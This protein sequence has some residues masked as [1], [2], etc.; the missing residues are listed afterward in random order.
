MTG[1]EAI[2]SYVPE[3]RCHLR[4]LQSEVR[5]SATQVDRLLYDHK[6]AFIA[7]EPRQTAASMMTAAADSLLA[8]HDVQPTNIG[9]ILFTHTLNP[10][11]PYLYDPLSEWRLSRQLH[12]AQTMS[13]AQMNCASINLLFF[14]AN[15]WLQQTPS[16][17]G[18]LLMTADKMFIP[19]E[20]YLLDSSMAGDAA[21]AVYLTRDAKRSRLIRTFLHSEATIYD[22]PAS[23]PADYALFQQTFTFG[24]IKLLRTALRGCRLDP[25]QI[26]CIFPSNLNQTTWL[27]V[28]RALNMPHELFYYPT[29]SEVGHCHNADPILNLERGLAENLL[30]PGDYYLILTAGMGG[31][32]GCSVFQY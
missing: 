5:I 14:L 31:T 18:V 20:R 2:G 21:V 23:S 19:Q 3:Q 1:I 25:E 4:E 32:F 13:A 6:L 30:R 15:Q 22:G 28:A 8:N 10:F 11:A 9:Q 17:P 24:L 7:I 26:R 12:E 27:R 29:L 16:S